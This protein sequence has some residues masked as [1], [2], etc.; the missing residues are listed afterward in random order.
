MSANVP[1]Q[2]ATLDV[3][4]DFS[5]LSSKDRY[6][7]IISTIV[8]RPIAWVVTLDE[9]GLLNAAP[10]SFF[11]AFSTDPAVVGI[12]I[13]THDSGRPKDTRRNIRDTHQFVV[14]LVSEEMAKAMNIT[15]ITFD[16]EV[17]EI[18]EAKLQTRP[19]TRI[20]PPRIAGSPVA[21]ECELMQI[22]D[23][24]GE[25]ELVLGRV[26]AMH[27]RED[28]VID[29][30]KHYVDTAKLSLIGRMHGSGFYTRTSDLF[31]I[32]RISVADWQAKKRAPSPKE[33]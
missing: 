16:S 8:P 20:R 1:D 11:N 5:T 19:S 24:G 21:L 28:A 4:F 3:L 30:A 2:S 10:F 33:V 12:G 29:P 23:L 18:A 32:D 9:A 26:L 22:V 6:K 31:R 17:D 14:N 27:V 7:L 13:G 25:A 15:A